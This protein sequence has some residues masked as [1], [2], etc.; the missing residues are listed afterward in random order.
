[1]LGLATA[2]I[3]PTV[4]KGR[5]NTALWVAKS[6][7]APPPKNTEQLRIA[8]DELYFLMVVEYATDFAPGHISRQILDILI[9]VCNN[10]QSPRPQGE[11]FIGQLA[12]ECTTNIIHAVLPN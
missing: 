9:D 5:N 7:I 1:M 10:P 8:S 12:K 11:I 6:D 3:Y 4:T 2:L